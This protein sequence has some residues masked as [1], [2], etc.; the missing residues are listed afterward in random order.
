MHFFPLQGVS[1]EDIEKAEEVLRSNEPAK[2]SVLTKETSVF[3]GNGVTPSTIPTATTTT[4]ISSSAVD[5]P[6]K[7]DTSVLSGYRRRHIEN[8][9]R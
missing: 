7:E 5:N 8:D 6:S 1:L 9:V 3:G 4:T 2:S